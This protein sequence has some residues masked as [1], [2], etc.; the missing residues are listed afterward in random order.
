VLVEFIYLEKAMFIDIIWR[1]NHSIN[2]IKE[3][4]KKTVRSLKPL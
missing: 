3:A 2:L 1:E 4:R